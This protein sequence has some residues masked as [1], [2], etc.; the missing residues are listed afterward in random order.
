MVFMAEASNVPVITVLLLKAALERA[1]MAIARWNPNH[2]GPQIK[3][4]SGAY[5][6]YTGLDTM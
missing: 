5:T 2:R 4:I 6:T 3:T 1:A